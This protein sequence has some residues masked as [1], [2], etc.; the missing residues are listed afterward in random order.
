MQ[1]SICRCECQHGETEC[2][3]NQLMNCVID[4]LGFPE[5]YLDHIV[6]MQ[7]KYSFE[8]ALKCTENTTLNKERIRECAKGKRGRR[9]LALSGQ[10]TVG[11]NPALD[12]VPWVMID[13]VRNGDAFY[14][15]TQNVCQAMKNPSQPCLEYLKSVI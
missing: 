15:L 12:F 7:G 3:I 9:L 1:E 10:K 5:R 14:D 13:G 4:Q 11:L 8:E 6:C 2:E